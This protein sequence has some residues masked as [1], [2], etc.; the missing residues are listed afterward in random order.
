MSPQPPGLLRPELNPDIIMMIA[1]AGHVDHGKTR[2]V[3]MLTGCQTDR[4][5]EEQERGLTIELGFAPCWI[6]GN[7]CV[8]IVDVPGHEAFV[9]TMVAGVS[10]IDFAIL[11]IAADDGI[12]PQTIEHLDIMSLMGVNRGVVALT[13]I[14]LV[15]RDLIE[16]RRSEIRNFLVGTPLE[17]V[18]IC[19]L[20]S[21]TFE[22]YE[23]F[24]EYLISSI[25]ARA[26]ERGG[27]IFRMPIAQF[28]SRAGFGTIVTGIP[29]DGSVAVGDEVELVPDGL[30]GRIRGMQQFS[31]DAVEGG[32]GQ[33][34]ALNIP[35]FSKEHLAR[36]KVLSVPGYLRPVRQIHLRLS[37]IQK[38]ERP[39]QNAE[40]IKFHTGTCEAGGKLYLLEE[41]P[42]T[43]GR[44]SPAMVILD[45][46]ISAAPNDRFILRRL[47]P[48]STVAGG[49]ILQVKERIRREPRKELAA[50][51][52]AQE[53]FL[54]GCDP[55]SV[56]WNVRRIEYFLLKDRPTGASLREISIGTLL[57]AKTVREAA[58]HLTAG[59]TLSALEPEFFIH[60]ASYRAFYESVQARVL[61]AGEAGKA[62][63]LRR[64]ELRREF[65]CPAPLWDRLLRDLEQA[66][67]VSARGHKMVLSGAAGNI[68]QAEA[69]LLD[70]LRNIYSQSG[71]QSPRPDELPGLLGEPEVRIRKALEHLTNSEELVAVSRSVVLTAALARK[72]QDRVVAI[73]Q[74]R[75]VLNSADFKHEIQ[76]SRKYALAILDWLDARH[77]TLRIGNDRKLSPDYRKHLF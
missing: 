44:T 13:K 5:K 19:P 62:L 53:D 23:A 72:A 8:G 1:T 41:T 21:E 69:S 47:S 18:P 9:R 64:E 49:T 11:V 42:L 4:L 37:S 27:G 40:L 58:G 12:M 29:V 39:L 17:G 65:D 35:E 57:P 16:Q 22:G 66:E 24:F 59:G 76:S 52:A 77:V 7:L 51:L 71:F 38:L 46:P 25:K 28:F 54:A 3:N 20:S 31:R 74:E 61:Q 43:G 63:S 68:A 48:A 67:L 26:S 32:C 75:G 2:L 36:G 15:D 73:I 6:G 30:T 55:G 50:A 33:C 34:L 45:N 10:G 14:D 56:P 70:R 60:A